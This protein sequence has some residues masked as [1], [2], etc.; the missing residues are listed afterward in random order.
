MVARR[1]L[2]VDDNRDSADSLGMLMT[3][4]GHVV[5]VAYDGPSAIEAARDFKPSV[6]CLDIGMPVMNGF[7]VAQALR[8]DPSFASVVLI[9]L[10][11]WSEDENQARSREAGFDHYLVKPVKLETLETLLTKLG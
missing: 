6:I 4:L 8:A 5:R 1:I 2:M 9:A 11:G 3:F 7:E 10:T